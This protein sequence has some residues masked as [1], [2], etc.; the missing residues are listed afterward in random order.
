VSEIVGLVAMSHSP[1]ATMLPPADAAEPGGRFLVR[2][3]S[4]GQDRGI[5]R[6]GAGVPVLRPVVS[7]IP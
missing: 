2:V 1:F 4:T 3:Q 6:F 7:R 5:S